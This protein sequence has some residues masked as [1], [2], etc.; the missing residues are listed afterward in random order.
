MLYD[1]SDV[2]LDKIRGKLKRQEHGSEVYLFNRPYVVTPQTDLESAPQ[3]AGWT[4][5]HRWETLQENVKTLVAKDEEGRR[6]LPNSQMHD[7]RA[8]LF[9]GKKKEADARY[10]LIR[11]R[12]R[13][14]GI[15]NLAGS[16][17]SLFQPEPESGIYMTRLLDAIDAADFLG[18]E[19][20]SQ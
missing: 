10:R 4:A 1:S 20:T 7:L 11:D 15:V 9:L 12:Y 19:G 6:K 2:A 14:Q 16:E 17:E 8:G 5:F 18:K 13:D 3:G